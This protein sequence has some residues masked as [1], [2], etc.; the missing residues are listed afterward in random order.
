MKRD[1]FIRCVDVKGNEYNIL[2]INVLEETGN[3]TAGLF[4]KPTFS[5]SPDG[6]KHTMPLWKYPTIRHV[7]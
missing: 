3:W 4:R 2:D 1:D 6:R 5:T 7:C